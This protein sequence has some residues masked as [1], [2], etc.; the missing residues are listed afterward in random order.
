[1]AREN[2]ISFELN[3]ATS[4]VEV[5]TT[6]NPVISSTVKRSGS[7]ALKIS[8]STNNRSAFIG[9]DFSVRWFRAYLWIDT[10]PD[11]N[12]VIMGILNATTLRCGIRL[13]TDGTLQLMDEDGDIGS[14]SA[15][16]STA[17]WYRLELHLDVSGAGGTHVI[18]ARVNGS[19]F[20]TANNRN[21]G[22]SSNRCAVGKRIPTGT[23]TTGI[24]YFDDLAVNS[25]T[26]SFQN[27][28]PGEGSVL[29]LFPNAAGD[30]TQWT[31]SAGSNFQCVDDVTPNDATDFVSSNTLDQ[32]D[33]YNLG[34]S[35]ISG[36]VNV[37]H[38]HTRQADNANTALRF[39]TRIKA[40]AA[41]TVEESAALNSLGAYTTNI[42]NFAPELTLYDL[43]GASTTAWTPTD[44][45]AAQ[46]GIRISTGGA[47][48]TLDVTAIWMVV[49]Y[50]A[51]AA[52]T[53]DAD[54][55]SYVLTGT[56]ATLRYSKVVTANSGSYAISGTAANLLYKRIMQ[57]V[58][59]SYVLTGTAANLRLGL[60][61]VADSGV[62]QIT[63]TAA[64]LLRSRRLVSDAGTYVITG[65][66]ADLE[67]NRIL[68]ALA[69]SYLITGV[70]AALIT[71]IVP[72]EG[73]WTFKSPKRDR[74]F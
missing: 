5:G 26:G 66:P 71:V 55:G 20:A 50:A 48:A 69:G 72:P 14:P 73:W 19:D 24:Y 67:R 29:Y 21:V 53:L 58:A 60:N 27:S 3:T 37:V 38:V 7:Y 25:N 68:Q 36:V 31:P 8:G 45:D 41:G 61:M 43:P 28:W 10:L 32:I 44:L 39:R 30:N 51:A 12:D 40:S 47:G 59:G 65:T 23:D 63:G 16:L 56:A 22:L 11:A 17:T 33:D 35:G 46:I 15:A 2:T 49:E 62:Y 18:T 13:N 1:M 42:S 74:R 52:T 54:P 57:A 9:G 4:A 64:N 6:N 70:P 34:A